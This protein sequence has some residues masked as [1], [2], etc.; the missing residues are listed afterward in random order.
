MELDE[1]I[2]NRY[3]GIDEAQKA[4]AMFCDILNN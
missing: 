4:Y 3:D 2:L 1:V